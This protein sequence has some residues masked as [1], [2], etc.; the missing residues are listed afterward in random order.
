MIPLQDLLDSTT[1]RLS[2]VSESPELDAQVLLAHVLDKPR[3][4]VVAHTDS[5]P[6][7]E[8][9]A[10]LE[11]L[12]HRLEEG[13]PLPYV[14]GH[15]EFYGLDFEITPDVLIPRPETELLVERAV[16]WL[17]AAPERRTIADIGTGSGCIAVCLAVHVPGARI[18]GTD[19]SR[20]AL[21]VALHNAR[22]H[23]VSQQI[24]LVQCDILPQHIP[25]LSTDHHFDLVCA[26]LPYIPTGTLRDLPV[27]GREP[28]LALDGGP[29][30]LDPFRKLFGLVADWMAPGGRILLEIEATR[31]SA[32][33]S[34]AYDAFSAASIHLHRDLAGHDRLLEIQFPL[35]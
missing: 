18:L 29:D 3:T 14:L 7:P 11:P 5:P 6:D 25:G 17:M 16:A 21:G 30:G 28:T 1:A 33:L 34:L 22:K 26:N 12:L 24:D 23:E 27:F 2:A 13:E 20:P 4:W 19:I 10:I 9:V 35:A 31:G 32:V 15:Q 8:A